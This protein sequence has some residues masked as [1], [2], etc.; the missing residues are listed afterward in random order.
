MR[1]HYSRRKNPSNKLEEEM[2]FNQLM[3]LNKKQKHPSGNEFGHVLGVKYTLDEL[4]EAIKTFGFD[5]YLD[6]K[7]A[8]GRRLYFD[9]YRVLNDK[10]KYSYPNKDDY[11]KEH[12]KLWRMYTILL[13]HVH[14]LRIG[15]ENV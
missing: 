12:K 4:N 7:E 6:R 1:S 14:L 5:P 10:L 11:T 3:K 9:K 15:V 13:N 8:A 2:K